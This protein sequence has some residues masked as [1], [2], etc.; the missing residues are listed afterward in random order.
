ME[1]R[2]HE[3]YLAAAALSF[4]WKD[5]EGVPY[6]AKGRVRDMSASGVFVLADDVPP[7]GAYV[8]IEVFMRSVLARSQLVIEGEGPVVR[9]EASPGARERAGF[10]AAIKAFT[11]RNEK[12]EVLE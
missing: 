12:G 6:R 5:P 2:R 7:V 3:R 11:L 1:R 9:V 10:A 4:L 8:G